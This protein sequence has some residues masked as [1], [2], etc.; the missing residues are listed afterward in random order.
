ML[1]LDKEEGKK[2]KYRRDRKR[3]EAGRTVVRFR[4]TKVKINRS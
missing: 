3:Q 1:R 4:V 2:K